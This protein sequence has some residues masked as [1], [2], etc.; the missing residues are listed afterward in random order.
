MCRQL[1]FPQLSYHTRRTTFGDSRIVMELFWKEFYADSRLR[2]LV[3]HVMRAYQVIY[4]LRYLQKYQNFIQKSIVF[5]SIFHAITPLYEKKNLIDD[6][7]QEQLATLAPESQTFELDQMTIHDNWKV[8]LSTALDTARVVCWTKIVGKYD[9]LPYKDSITIMERLAQQP[10][11]Y[12]RDDQSLIM[13]QWEQ[14]IVKVY[15]VFDEYWKNTFAN[16][17]R[18]TQAIEPSSENGPQNQPVPEAG[19]D[20]HHVD[21]MGE[22]VLHDF[23]S[24]LLETP[25]NGKFTPNFFTSGCFLRNLKWVL[26]TIE[27]YH[28]FEFDLNEGLQGFMVEFEALI[29]LIFEVFS[30]PQGKV[31]SRWKNFIRQCRPSST[32]YLNIMEECIQHNTLP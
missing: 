29:H 13:F 30:I 6:C 21:S 3:Q 5:Q 1:V 14:Y 15:R 17:F 4:P 2:D 16:F 31:Y 7:Y 25:M 12:C 27:L 28:F 9:S 23:R 10:S 11:I 26:D 32:M 8:E 18:K 22:Q 20:E 19:G 24:I